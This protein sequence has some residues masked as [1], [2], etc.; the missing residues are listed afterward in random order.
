MAIV[1]QSVTLDQLDSG[2]DPATLTITGVTTGSLL[3]AGAVIFRKS[4][5]DTLDPA[6]TDNAG[7]VLKAAT[8]FLI[9]AG[10]PDSMGCGLWYVENAASGSHTFS[11]PLGGGV[12]PTI[13]AFISEIPTGWKSSSLDKTAQQTHALAD[14]ATTDSINLPLTT[15]GHTIRFSI[16]TEGNAAGGSTNIG[17]TVPS[18]DT[19]VHIGQ[20]NL[21]SIPIS[22]SFQEFFVD[23]ARTV[24]WNWTDATATGISAAAV[25]ADFSLETTGGSSGRIIS[26]PS[27]FGPGL[28]KWLTRDK[29][30]AIPDNRP[31]PIMPEA[32]AQTPP[33]EIPSPGFRGPRMLE[34]LTRDKKPAIPDSQ[35]D[36]IMPERIARTPGRALPSTG[37][38]GMIPWI[39]RNQR[40]AFS[41]GGPASNIFALAPAAL[42]FIGARASAITKGMTATLSFIGNFVKSASKGLAVATLSFIGALVIRTNKLMTAALS[43]IGAQSRVVAK[44]MTAAFSFIGSLPRAVSKGMTAALSFVGAQARAVSYHLTA[45]LSFIGTLVGGQLKVK[46]LAAA[47]SF[48]GGFA[49]VKLLLQSLAAAL[50]FSGAFSKRTNKGMT[51]ALSFIGSSSRQIAKQMTA[52]ANFVGAYVARTSKQLSATA[53]SFVGS[54]NLQARKLMTAALSFI[55]AITAG[56]VF[57]KAVAAALSFTGAF[58]KLPNKALSAILSFSGIIAT[59][60]QLSGPIWK[61]ARRAAR[62]MIGQR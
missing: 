29:R 21:S 53:L 46:A 12:N 43:F 51:A 27:Q 8:A 7:T 58:G 40:P 25:A 44:G 6:V 17:L 22:G 4:E 9:F 16:W 23:A 62:W 52:A 31:D 3:V 37:G 45:A 26:L 48:I 5:N 59:G 15:K 34:W 2:P 33:G 57:L 11:F 47:L 10:G 38:P 61:A 24:T 42:S 36:P 1:K 54:V 50:S 49:S 13:H 19:Q 20:N 41:I 55:G 18:G 28:L 39:Q 32:I 14:L 56:R 30:P 60:K 35:P